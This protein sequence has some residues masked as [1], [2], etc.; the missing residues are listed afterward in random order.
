MWARLSKMNGQLIAAKHENPQ[1]TFSH[2][3]AKCP[4][5]LPPGF[6]R[7]MGMRYTAR[8]NLMLCSNYLQQLGLD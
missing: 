6:G 1:D 3:E 7:C 4:S 8:A 2:K 5:L